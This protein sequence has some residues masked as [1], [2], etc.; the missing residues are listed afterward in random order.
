MKKRHQL[1]IVGGGPVGVALAVDLGLR[2]IS[3]VLVERRLEP[4]RIPK[5]QNLT[6]RTVE[7]FYFWGIADELRA[8]RILPPGYPMNGIVAYDNLMSE[9]WYAPPLREIVNSYYFQKNERLPQY[10]TEHVLRARMAQLA[11]VESRIG[12]SARSIEQN[13]D[14]VRVAI[15]EEGGSGRE[16]LEAEYVVGCDGGPS[17]VRS[18][19]G[20]ERGGA[21][22]NQLMV[23]AVFRSRE[24][25]EGLK[26]F[27]ARST[28][29]VMHPGFEGLLAVLRP[30]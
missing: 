15:H 6:Q 17:T 19:I 25:H 23:L 27:P 10:Q 24:L 9:Y 11:N 28:Y 22:F 30:G 4:Q 29:R 12:W 8:A 20:I 21:D 5:G 26:R 7:H 3:C 1:I 18:Q 13:A 16:I 2:G 14:G